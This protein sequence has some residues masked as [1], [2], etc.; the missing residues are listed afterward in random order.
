MGDDELLSMSKYGYIT[1]RYNKR[2]NSEHYK[3]PQHASNHTLFF[4]FS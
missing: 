2:Y 3:P 4:L 1:H